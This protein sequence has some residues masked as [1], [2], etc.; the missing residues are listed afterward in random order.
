MIHIITD[1]ASDLS[2]AEAKEKEVILI[3]LTVMCNSVICPCETN[4]DRRHFYELLGTSKAMPTTSQ[5]SPSAYLEKFNNIKAA[6]DEAVVLCISAG[7]SGTFQSASIAA[8]MAAYDKITVLDTGSVIMGQRM[9][10]DRAVEMRSKGAS[11]AEIA[12]MVTAIKDKMVVCGVVDTLKYLK[13]GGRIPASLALIG[14]ALNLKPS[15]I[16]QNGVIEPL[17]KSRGMKQG[18]RKLHDEY[19]KFQTD[20]KWPVYFGYV[21]IKEPCI[22]FMNETC[23]KYGIEG[24]YLYPV[25]PTI[26]VHTGPGC[27]VM[28]FV[29]K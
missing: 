29:R 8:K 24:R 3:P 9:I 5:P 10:V 25:G 15:L 1:T 19:E 6:G 18:I 28:T 4:E 17:G 23:E 20:S 2:V 16:I 21:N 13:K 22:N 27:I 26:G 12:N 7:L 11:A 14:E